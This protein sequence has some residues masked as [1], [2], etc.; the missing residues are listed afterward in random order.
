MHYDYFPY[1]AN[2]WLASVTLFPD[3]VLSHLG[4]V[5]VEID[6]KLEFATYLNDHK[7]TIFFFDC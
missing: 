5:F 4:Y 3:T 7:E 6:T 2:N 1:E